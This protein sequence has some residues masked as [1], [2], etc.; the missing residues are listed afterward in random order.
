MDTNQLLIQYG[1]IYSKKLRD[2]NTVE[3]NI[4]FD[5]TIKSQRPVEQLYRNVRLIQNSF[6]YVHFLYI[7]TVKTIKVAKGKK[8]S[9]ECTGAIGKNSTT[10]T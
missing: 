7:G 3:R 9:V 5:L 8:I 2:L 1:G 6:K 4:P 10:S